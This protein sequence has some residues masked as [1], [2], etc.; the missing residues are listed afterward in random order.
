[1]I[2]VRNNWSPMG[3]A[4]ALREAMDR[5]FD[6]KWTRRAGWDADR[7]VTPPADAWEDENQVVIELALPGVEA[8]SVDVRYEKDVLTV[9]GS[10]A[11]RDEEKQWVLKERARGAFQREFNLRAQVDSDK[12]EAH[13]AQGILSLRLPKSEAVKPR[14]IPVQAVSA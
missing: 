3:E 4:L 2:T 6:E 8:E 5:L 1:M 11:A 12:A 10:F 7:V 9:S 14:K 13:F